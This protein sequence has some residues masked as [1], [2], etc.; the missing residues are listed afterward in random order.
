MP[1]TNWPIHAT[2]TSMV[3]PSRL[4]GSNRLINSAYAR[5]DNSSSLWRMQLS[6]SRYLDADDAVRYSPQ[7]SSHADHCVT[8]VGS[9]DTVRQW[10]NVTA[11]QEAGAEDYPEAVTV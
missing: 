4:E 3:T 1:V 10:F 6:P 8:G 5:I 9:S 2:G 7:C 11:K